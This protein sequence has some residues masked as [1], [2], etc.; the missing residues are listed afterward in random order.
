MW[1]LERKPGSLACPPLCPHRLRPPCQLCSR[2]SP[3]RASPPAIPLPFQ[4][5]G[6][7]SSHS[8]LGRS[9]LRGMALGLC[10]SPS[11]HR[12]SL[13][14]LAS[15]GNAWPFP[16]LFAVRPPSGCPLCQPAHELQSPSL[17]SS[18]HRVPRTCAHRP[19]SGRTG[20]SQGMRGSLLPVALP[21]TTG[22]HC[23]RWALSHICWQPTLSQESSLTVWTRS[24]E[25]VPWCWCKVTFLLRA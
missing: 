3:R 14:R 25:T 24:P 23:P 15:L 18:P 16:L 9:F 4:P 12:C 10:G 20:S 6:A 21:S 22:P 2:P 19:P 8:L 11:H 17:V 1:L 7:A 5:R 13:H